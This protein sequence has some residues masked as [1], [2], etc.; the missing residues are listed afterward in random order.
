MYLE[1][2]IVKGESFV[3]RL[4]FLHVDVQL[5]LHHLLKILSLPH[6]IVFAPVLKIN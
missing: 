6:C 1:S 2:V 4:I 3:A 5:L